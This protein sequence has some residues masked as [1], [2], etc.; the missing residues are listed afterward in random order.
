MHPKVILLEWEQDPSTETLK[1]LT[2]FKA[3]ILKY[4]MANPQLAYKLAVTYKGSGRSKS[5][6]LGIAAL[7]ESA[8]PTLQE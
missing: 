8:L 3:N 1:D 7:Y 5:I 4:S 2:H 6:K